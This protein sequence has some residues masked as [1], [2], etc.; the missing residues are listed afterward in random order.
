MFENLILSILPPSGDNR[1]PDPLEK[2]KAVSA[3]REE[4]MGKG[5]HCVWH[6]ALHCTAL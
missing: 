5:V 3:I 4:S 2:R 1:A 6:T